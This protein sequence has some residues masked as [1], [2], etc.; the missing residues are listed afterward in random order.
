VSNNR[1]GIGFEIFLNKLILKLMIKL[2]IHNGFRSLIKQMPYSFV[3]ILGMT[4]GVASVLVLLIWI[5]AETSYDK[6]HKDVDRLYRV[7]ELM[8][9]PNKE[10]NIAEI[11]APAG[12]EFKKAFP[13]VENMVRFELDENPV[14]YKDRTNKLRV[15][16]TDS[17]FFDMFSFDLV[18]GNRQTCLNSPQGIVLT[19]KSVKR[20]FGTEDPLGK[21]VLISG[22]TFT[23]TAVAK[24][25]PINTNMQFE[26]LAPLS[27][28]SRKAHIGWDGGLSCYTYLKLIK[29]T[30]PVF[31]EKQIMDYMEGA[32]NK[33]YREFG[34]SLNP[35]LQKI[36]DIHLR[37]EAEYELGDK[38]SLKQIILFS[39][40]GL[41]ILLIACFNFVNINTALSFKRS[42]EV[43]VKKIF[44]SDKKNIVLFFVVESAL[45]IFISLLMAFLLVKILLPFASGVVG[46]GLSLTIIKPLTWVMIYASVFIFCTV[47]ASFYGSVYLSSISPLVLLSSINRGKKKQY[48][49][50]ILV[51][52][53]YTISIAMI[54]SC[55]VIYF[56][57][58]F[59]KKIDKGFNE[60]NILLIN[61]NSKTAATYE[62][63]L[64]RFSSI[65][66]VESVSVSAGGQPGV[67]FFMNGYVPE[68]ME[69]PMLA[70]AVYVDENYLKTLGITMIDGRNFRN[71]R[72]EN[73]KAIINQTFARIVG[74]NKVEGKSI[75]RNGIKYEVIGIVKDFNTSSLYNKTEPI[76]ISTVNEVGEFEKIV[77]KYTPSNLKDVLKTCESILKDISPD[78]PFEYDFLE[79][80]MASS[81]SKDQRMNLL[82][83]VLAVIAIF[84]SSLGLFGLATFAT[85]SRMK[86][87]S[88]N[89]INGATISDIYRRFNFELLKW[90]IIS[91]IIAAPV[92]YFFM[93][94]WLRTFAYKTSISI[95]LLLSSGL[96][97]LAIGLLTVS[98]A[99]NKAARTNPAETLRKE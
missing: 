67:G 13:V 34:Y 78:F 9:T 60:K 73:N 76:F 30:D 40:I 15:L 45:A 6:F 39:G 11:N 85:Q 99:A 69:K 88:I 81:Y 16:Y 2:L 62:S 87:I 41:L 70:R 24:D 59:V 98:W 35:Y 38:G 50:N 92:G 8:K 82:F 75:S 48:S 26:C 23:V 47:F 66:G 33:K 21:G 93:N 32:I 42:K 28:I 57:M 83:L 89:K 51:T 55:L 4:I 29:G 54:I 77:V 56:Q 14:V 37:S 44:G 25:P 1:T 72:S 49:R 52:F 91:F 46:E 84:I 63:I 95:W 22:E 7:G 96:L 19:E 3:N 71:I 5:S 68:G 74:W 80:L 64:N 36:S 94:R 79:D 31:L 17:T 97:T 27:V 65:P 43:S 53:Q 20:I 86:E 18:T 10:I 12:P 61:L 58:Q 90:I